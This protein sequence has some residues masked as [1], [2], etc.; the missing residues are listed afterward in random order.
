MKFYHLIAILVC[1]SQLLRAAVDISRPIELEE[2]GRARAAAYA[3]YAV[4]IYLEDHPDAEGRTPEAIM[5]KYLLAL[6]GVDNPLMA[7]RRAANLLD[8]K[9]N[10]L[11]KEAYFL[12]MR[13]ILEARS[14]SVRQRI[15]L[16]IIL[17]GSKELENGVALLK[18]CL[19]EPGDHRGL[20]YSILGQHF[21][22]QNDLE[23]LRALLR[24]LEGE[25][26][27]AQDN[28][29]RV[30]RM[31]AYLRLENKVAAAEMAAAMV[32]DPVTYTRA[33]I[34]SELFDDL[35]TLGY[36]EMTDAFLEQFIL[37]WSDKLEDDEIERLMR[38][39]LGG[40]VKDD[41]PYLFERFID[42]ALQMELSDKFWERCLPAM[43]GGAREHGEGTSVGR[44]YCQTIV[45]Y[46]EEQ[47]RL[48]PEKR[49]EHAKAICSLYADMGYFYSAIEAA[50]SIPLVSM[51]P[52]EQYRAALLLSNV[53][54]NAEALPFF[55]RLEKEWADN[56]NKDEVERFYSC[57]SMSAENAGDTER[58]I[59]LLERAL[60]KCPHSPR[61]ANALGYT[62]ADH[63]RDL[64][65]AQALIEEALEKEKTSSAYLDSL[66]WVHFRQGRFQA[67][68]Q[69]ML[70]ALGTLSQE[71][72]EA[73][74]TDEIFE[75]LG[76]I[77]AAMGHP[78]A[79]Q[80][81]GA[82]EGAS[83]QK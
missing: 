55:D 81:W 20:A 68:F 5:E 25:P 33:G 24:R 34:L 52:A 64:E 35:G 72:W 45:R 32:S 73:S 2:A 37:A 80:C 66:A 14:P 71:E 30:M 63:N 44:V 49:L 9:D 16:A 4:G 58:A 50:L 13:H 11:D 29:L 70:A 61:L 7:F 47:Q 75:H 57:Y 48:E 1:V 40:I 51:T 69:C 18:A 19:E 42:V 53:G 26:D 27:L 76:E 74:E 38:M 41:N 77:L 28:L 22:D 67:A 15:C 39:R 12:R 21:M 79:A 17:L 6:A 54:R 46:L 60:E 82:A 83:S 8:D 43:V 59:L 10:K 65:R 62:L 36:S 56:K 31:R 3:A 78:A 23:E